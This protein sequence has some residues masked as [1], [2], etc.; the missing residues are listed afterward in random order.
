[1]TFSQEDRVFV[2]MAIAVLLVLAVLTLILAL[3]FRGTF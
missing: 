2:G 3:H 1:M